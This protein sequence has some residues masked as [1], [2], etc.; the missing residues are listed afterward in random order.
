MDKKVRGSYVDGAY[1]PPQE[2]PVIIRIIR[3]T[4]K[5]PKPLDENKDKR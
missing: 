1:V 2:D 4:Q 5:N 3:P